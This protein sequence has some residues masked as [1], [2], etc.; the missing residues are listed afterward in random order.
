[1]GNQQFFDNEWQTVLISMTRHFIDLKFLLSS[2]TKFERIT[3]VFWLL[4]PMIMLVERSPADVWI[5]TIALIF[6]ARAIFRREAWWLKKTWVRFAFLFWA[7]C[8]ASALVS[9]HPMY[10]L[11]EAFVWFRFPLF[12]MA[13][14]FW[15]GRDIRL[16]YAMLVSTGA[17]MVLMCVILFAELLIV[18]A[19]NNRLSWPYG[20]LMPGNYLAKACLPAFV[21]AVA[22]AT[23][24][25]T[26]TAS[27]SAV[28][29]LFSIVASIAT[30]ERINFLI[31]ACSGMIAAIVWK[32]KL[33]RIIL[34][35]LVEFIIIAFALFA[36]PN[37]ADRFISVF[38]QELPTHADSPYL[39]VMMPGWLAFKESPWFGVGPGNL[40]FLCET[41]IANSPKYD[42]ANHPHNY[43]IQV[44]GEVGLIGFV[45]VVA[46]LGSVI[47]T[48]FKPRIGHRASVVAST[49]WIVPFGLFW[50]ISS[51][52]DFF[53]Q[54]NN[55]FL[56]SAVGLALA[57]SQI[58]KG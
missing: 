29:A 48:C 11:G 22:L 25:S 12:A 53:G 10:S 32:P 2:M 41:L 24:A 28:V 5:T 18:G 33:G 54:W 55:I 1:M 21:I 31:R 43:Y 16:V 37:V 3:H 36:N 7:S 52:A 26:R 46:F 50:P 17:G 15:L 57:G 38:F 4:G 9:P 19:T 20:D 51:T 56:W 27:L 13:T 40:R 58:Q 47:W 14:A 8:I 42:C 23:S 45:S 39:R 6:V 35:F 44:L 34:L 30:G 49:M